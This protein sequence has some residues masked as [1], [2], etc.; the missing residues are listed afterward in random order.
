MITLLVAL[1]FTGLGF[2]Q[3]GGVKGEDKVE[4]KTK[5][6][7]K[8][9]LFIIGG[10]TRSAELTKQMLA[11]AQLGR[12]DY[13][14]V[15][16]MSSGEKDT[17]FYYFKRSV[18]SLCSNAV[19]NLDFTKA[20][21]NNAQ[22][23]DSLAKAKLIY[24]TGG[25]QTRFMNIVL[26]TP[27]FDKIHE[28]YRNGATI[29]GTSA[30]AAVMSEQMITGKNTITDSSKNIPYRLYAEN[31]EVAKGLGLLKSV[32]IDQHFIARSR[33]NRLLSLLYRF[34]KHTGIGIDESTAI[35]VDGKKVT[36]AGEGQVVVFAD[37]KGLSLTPGGMIRYEHLKTSI[38]VAGDVFTIRQ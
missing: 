30:G 21:V 26:N 23:L 1:V 14:A 17:S 12:H 35:I 34:P 2:S 37:P 16:P 31:T 32:I 27:V 28:A 24:I 8:G 5:I 33:Y 3:G 29:A 10:G 22:R 36:V 20:D 9:K 15:L 4:V 13:I 11:T 7:V 18:D 6:E 25:Q 38:Y 19:V